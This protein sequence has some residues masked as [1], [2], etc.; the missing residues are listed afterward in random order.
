MLLLTPP[1]PGAEESEPSTAWFGP[2]PTDISE[3]RTGVLVP[4]GRPAHARFQDVLV[5]AAVLTDADIRILPEGL[6]D[7]GPRR[8]VAALCRFAVS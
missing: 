3:H 5:R 8:G 2:R 7:D 1:E 4:D 6:E